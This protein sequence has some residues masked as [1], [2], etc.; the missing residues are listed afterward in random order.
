MDSLDDRVAALIAA[1]VADEL[2]PDEADELD[3]LRRTHPWLDDEIATMRDISLR[4]AVSDLT[5]T[6]VAPSDELRERI[7]ATTRSDAVAAS[8]ES[9][10]APLSPASAPALTPQQDLP[11]RRDGRRPRRWITPLLGAA[12]VAIGLGAGLAIPSLVSTPPSG[13]PGTLGAVEQIDVRSEPAGAQIDAA[14]VA[15]TWGTEAVVDATGLEVGATYSVV[16]IGDDGTE[17]SAGE[18]LGSTVPIHCRLNAAVLREEAVRLEIREVGA[19]APP[20]VA[21]LPQT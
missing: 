3:D 14:L 2:T 6:E 9:V 10:P 15:H 20:A 1:A 17:F 11:V 5:W 4:L 16:F 18:M 21:D 7:A 8:S 13:G 12:C 19:N